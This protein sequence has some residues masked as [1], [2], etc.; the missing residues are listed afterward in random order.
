MSCWIIKKVELTLPYSQSVN[1]RIFFRDYAVLSF[2]C[3][4]E[5]F[6]AVLNDRRQ[7]LI[8]AC[9]WLSQK[10]YCCQQV[11]FFK[12]FVYLIIYLLIVMSASI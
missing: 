8:A 12:V 4:V 5:I 1:A 10:S 2:S 7:Q 11:S 6:H 3:D 9:T